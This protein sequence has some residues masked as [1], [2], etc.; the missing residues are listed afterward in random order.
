MIAL[1]AASV[2]IASIIVAIA[3]VLALWKRKKTDKTAETNYRVFFIMGV[4]LMPTG[5]SWMIV[6][7]LTELSFTI[8]L[9]FFILGAAYLAIGFENRGKWNKKQ[10]V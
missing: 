10:M 8:G 6:S 1:V 2:F 9:P 5:L 7:V 4:I 3:A